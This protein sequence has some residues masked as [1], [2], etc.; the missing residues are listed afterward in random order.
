MQTAPKKVVNAWAMY[1]WANSVFNLVITT[2]FF[3]IYYLGVT[4]DGN[5]ATKTDYIDFLW[6][7]HVPNSSLYNY[8]MATGFLIV[9]IMSPILSSIADYK[10]NK[11]S[12][13]RFLLTLGSLSCMGFYFFRSDTLLLGTILMITATVGY[14]SSLVFYNSY[15]PEIAAPQDRDRI[16][17]RGFMYGYIGSVLLQIIGFVLVML[18]GDDEAAQSNAVRITFVLVGIWWLSFA[19]ITLKNMPAGKPSG[20]GQN[21]NLLRNGFKELGKV[22]RQV[23]AMPVLWLF[24]CAF[25]F[26]NMGV[27]TIML[28]A[29][30][31]GK[32][33]LALDTTVLIA[34]VVIIQLVAIVGAITMS[35]L[36]EKYGN[37][38][39]LMAVVMLWI[40]VCVYAY[41]F[42]TNKWQFFGVAAVVG[43]VMGGIQSLSRS[44]YSK[45]MPVTKDT[46]SFF[47]FY[48]VTEKIAIVFGMFSFGFIT[49]VTGSMRNSILALITFFVLGLV[50]L[51][52]AYR[53]TKTNSLT[54]T[55]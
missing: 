35:R 15:L 13:M 31:F 38:R 39:V 32:E 45:L 50:I 10:G 16:S 52:F 24:L 55:D 6:L 23:K 9:A 26:Y 47:S 46:A 19:Q 18:A 7:K 37:F 8:T 2:T 42:L 33:E 14:W 5:E 36:S 28:I 1:D 11:K 49:Q 40:V 21:K 25:F 27:Q 22:L 29:T 30:N 12:F 48:D 41:F 54:E 3:P 51:L 53:R 43:L 20:D 17:A 44:T 4:G 34:T